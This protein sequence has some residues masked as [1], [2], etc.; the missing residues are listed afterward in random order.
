MDIR[1]ANRKL[2]RILNEQKR[3]AQE[4]GTRAKLIRRRLDELRAADSLAVM[5][6][7]PG[8]AFHLLTGDRKGQYAVTVRHPFRMIVIPL[9]DPVPLRPD[10]GIDEANVTIIEIQEIVDYHG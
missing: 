4:Y 10:G 9:H 3:L 6:T 7:V 1:F 2:E 8:A 5:R